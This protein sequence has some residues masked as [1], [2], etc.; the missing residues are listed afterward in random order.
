MQL[1]G[2]QLRRVTG[3]LS[4]SAIFGSPLLSTLWAGLFLSLVCLQLNMSNL[5][6]G[7]VNAIPNLVLP[8]QILSALFVIYRGKRRKPWFFAI[9]TARLLIL[10]LTLTLFDWSDPMKEWAPTLFIGLFTLFHLF[11]AFSTPAWFS[12]LTDLIPERELPGFWGKR[13]TLVFVSGL[14]VSLALG[15]VIDLPYDRGTILMFVLFAVAL[16][17]LTEVSFY[18]KVP[19]A[20]TEKV[21]KLSIFSLVRETFSNQ[22]FRAFVFFNGLYNFSVFL[23]VP[24]LFIHLDGLGYSGFS[25]QTIIAIGSLG[26]MLGAM[27][28]SGLAPITGNKSV[29]LICI[30][31]KAIAIFCLVFLTGESP[32]FAIG[33]LFFFDGFLNGG[34][35]TA[36][37]SLLGAETPQKNRSLFTAFYFSLTG[38]AGFA[39]ALSS[40]FLMDGLPSLFEQMGGVAI[41]PFHLLLGISSI[42]ILLSS[43]LLLPYRGHTQGTT[44]NT[45]AMLIEGNPFLSFVRLTQLK[46]RSSLRDRISFISRNRSRLFIADMLE[47][48]D[49]ASPAVRHA[50]VVSLGYISVPASVEALRPLVKNEESGLAV[51]ATKSLGRLKAREAVPELLSALDSP[52][53]ALR[54]SAAW[55]LGIIRDRTSL[56]RLIQVLE[57]EESTS[58][59]AALADALG[60][61]GDLSVIPLIL[62]RFKETLAHGMRLQF[63]VAMA[64][65][66]GEVGEF[67]EYLDIERRQPGKITSRLAKEMRK[68]CQKGSMEAQSF[69]QILEE[70]DD[71]RY[72]KAVRITFRL[73]FKRYYPNLNVESLVSKDVFEWSNED[74]EKALGGS[75]SLISHTSPIDYSLWV[76]TVLNYRGANKQEVSFEEALL[77]LYIL[78]KI[79]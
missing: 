23:F 5:Q 51:L 69:L 59:A 4:W 44:W 21:V 31:L 6:I 49:D 16:S 34:I 60:S 13:N 2:T 28:W 22:D 27:F 48:I 72:A 62:P 55:S 3:V 10:S 46:G 71:E 24:F 19:A 40:G 63:G 77:A 65:M 15:I 70:F 18:T 67:Y 25:I 8:G 11:Q 58:V 39:G 53:R 66:L 74:F 33:P 79:Y 42:L 47:A 32:W 54:S 14:L 68:L 1:K 26:A 61:F 7:F 64:N 20:D 38:L 41:T 73:A 57:K 17:G 29:L 78:R 36:N 37:F 45:V 12:W 9:I 30:S 43:T 75:D 56:K 76:L 50:A 52:D 35:L